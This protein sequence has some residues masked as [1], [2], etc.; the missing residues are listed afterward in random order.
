MHIHIYI[1]T[2]SYTHTHPHIFTHNIL[3]TVYCSFRLVISS[4]HTFYKQYF[5]IL[6][7]YIKLGIYCY[8]KK[9]NKLVNQI[10]NKES[11]NPC[12]VQTAAK[13]AGLI[14]H[15]DTEQI[16]FILFYILYLFYLCTSINIHINIYTNTNTHTHTHTHRYMYI[17]F[18]ILV[19][20]QM[21]V[22]GYLIDYFAICLKILGKCFKVCL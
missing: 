14:L 2:H 18:V 13:P 12:K 7:N 4:Y 15:S 11:N 10:Y 19:E 21:L 20:V 1:H 16:Y 5:Y 17:I 6:L 22:H 9:N 3:P 8:K